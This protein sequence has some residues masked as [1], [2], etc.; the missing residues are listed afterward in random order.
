[1]VAENPLGARAKR[2]FDAQTGDRTRLRV[3]VVAGRRPESLLLEELSGGLPVLL[4]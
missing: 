1:M 4:C 3:P 2:G